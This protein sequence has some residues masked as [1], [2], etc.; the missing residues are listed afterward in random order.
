VPKHCA[1]LARPLE[2]AMSALPIRSSTKHGGI[3]SGLPVT[4]EEFH[5]HMSLDVPDQT[6]G[7]FRRAASLQ[8]EA[9]LRLLSDAIFAMNRC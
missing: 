6:D 5:K 1:L 9:I 7:T 3:A 2:V 4:R 8:V